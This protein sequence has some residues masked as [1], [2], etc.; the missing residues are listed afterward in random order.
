MA[1]LAGGSSV[2]P[3]HLPCVPP[4]HLPYGARRSFIFVHQFLTICMLIACGQF[5]R[6]RT[7]FILVPCIQSP[8]PRTGFIL[9]PLIVPSLLY[10]C[11]VCLYSDTILT[12]FSHR[13]I[14][15]PGWF[16]STWCFVTS[17]QYVHLTFCICLCFCT[18]HHHTL[19]LSDMVAISNRLGA[20]LFGIRP[21]TCLLC[22]IVVRLRLS[23]L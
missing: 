23:R 8:R 6:P 13:L 12:L 2:G 19:Y 21:K 18:S 7:G 20:L 17:T 15:N 22:V 10:V 16:T 14:H 3:L 1:R 4:Q 5:P 9:H 11:N